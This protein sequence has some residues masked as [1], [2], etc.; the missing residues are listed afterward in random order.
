MAKETI[1]K[2]EIVA[3]QKDRR[4]LMKLLQTLPVMELPKQ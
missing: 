4:A 2:A 1:K 3:L